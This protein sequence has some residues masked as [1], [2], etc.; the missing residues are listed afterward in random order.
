MSLISIFV[1]IL[2]L[3]R[4]F[5]KTLELGVFSSLGVSLNSYL[6]ALLGPSRVSLGFMI[7]LAFFSI[8][9]DM[10]LFIIYS[11]SGLLLYSIALCLDFLQL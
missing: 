7:V 2:V 11:R 1:I 9:L 8:I 6:Y 5:M 4:A 3:L 10:L